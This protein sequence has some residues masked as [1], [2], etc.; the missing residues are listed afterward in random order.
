MDLQDHE[1]SKFDP[2]IPFRAASH[3]HHHT[4]A[5]TFHSYP[6]LYI[7]PHSIPELQK[8]VLLARQCRRR[9]ALT[10][11]GHSPSD[12]TCTS[13]W[14][15]NLDHMD[16]ILHADK[17]TNVVFMQAGIRLRDL[18]RKLREQHGLAMPNLGSIDHQSIAG[19]MA[20]ATHGSSTR[21][22]LLSQSVLGLKIMLANGKVVSCSKE[23]RP[24]LFR[25]ALVSLGAL[26]IITEVTLQAVPAFDI[27]WTQTLHPLKEIVGDW[28]KDIWTAKEFTRVWWMPY[29]KRCIKW[30]ADKTTKPRRP[31]PDNFWDGRVGFH[32]YHTLLYIAKWIPKILPLLEK[33][34][35]NVQ[36][37][38]KDG[39]GR[40]AVQEGHTGLLM[41]CLY[42]QFVNEWAIPLHK[43]P[44]ALTRFSAWLNGEEGSNIPFN[45]Q[46]VY[47]HAPI[48][49]RVTDTS[50][51]TP[52]PYLDN[53]VPDGA[54]LYLNA[55]LYRPYNSDPPSRERYYEAFEWLMKEMGG[56]PH[57]AK[58]FATVTK[59]DIREMYPD[60]GEYV[61]IRNE[62]DPEGMFVGDWHRRLI[63]P[64]QGLPL[65]ERKTMVKAASGGGIDWFG[66]VKAAR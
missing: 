7:Q 36:Y 2:E 38:L 37:G 55:T 62:V 44:E 35:M 53:T 64:E 50:S 4:W 18:G 15:V 3:H 48:E 42:S 11:C 14:L 40:S 1:L 43:G 51:T 49:V 5:R 56:R 21:H 23:Q 8:T 10:G 61:R 60:M 12:L 57:W 32:T 26:G 58:N 47:V 59:D 39:V 27:E 22:G 25:A 6:E 63:L 45:S 13:S 30:Q 54:T 66:E 16:E 9:I 65:E 24:D 19:A 41:N 17:E 46:G 28:E 20:T 29:M 31:P 33:F 34:V 52:R